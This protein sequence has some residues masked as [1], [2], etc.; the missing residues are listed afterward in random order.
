M[1]SKKSGFNPDLFGD[2]KAALAARSPFRQTRG[3]ANYIS[4]PNPCK[5]IL[6]RNRPSNRPLKSGHSSQPR[7]RTANAERYSKSP[8][9]FV[10]D[11]LF[12]SG[13]MRTKSERQ[14]TVSLE[15][16]PGQ[17]A[18]VCRLLAERQ[19]SIVAISVIDNVEQ[20][21]IRL[22][23]SDAA[24]CKRVLDSNGF[25]TIQGDV[26]VVDLGDG[27][28]KLAQIGHELAKAKINIDYVYG[29]VA[30]P[31]HPIRLVLKASDMIRAK[32]ILEQLG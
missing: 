28:G 2:K 24:E 16:Q 29:S 18:T 6:P 22:I 13:A 27:K 19:I 14:I 25:Y 26:L 12:F 9:Q 5:R 23:V 31:E 4:F 8:G 21:V 32:Q 20:G 11:M 1:A 15:N 7:T 17:L 30:D 3:S 10:Q